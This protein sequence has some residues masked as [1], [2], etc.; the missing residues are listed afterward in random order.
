MTVN[1][2]G[3]EEAILLKVIDS[4]NIY[5]TNANQDISLN[6]VRVIMFAAIHLNG[7]VQSVSPK[8][9]CLVKNLI[10]LLDHTNEDIVTNVR[11]TL[12]N[13]SDLPKGFKIIVHYLSN[14]ISHLDSV[15]FKKKFIFVK[16][17]QKF[18]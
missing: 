2:E 17:N 4:A 18:N 1:N 7:K 5:L 12:I 8:D 3:K 15:S 6:A 14:H 9:D 16:K 13:I 11:Q 10:S